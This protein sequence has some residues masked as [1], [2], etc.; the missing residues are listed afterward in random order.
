SDEKGVLK[1]AVEIDEA[2]DKGSFKIISATLADSG[3]TKSLVQSG[4]A[5]VLPGGKLAAAA[6]MTANGAQLFLSTVER[7]KGSIADLSVEL[8]YTYVVQLPAAKGRILFHWDKMQKAADQYMLDYHSTASDDD[9][10]VTKE[11]IQSFMN[12]AAEKSVVEFEFEGYN[13]DS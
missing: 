3:M 11:Q 6:N 5:P 8:N 12:F 7:R 2:E 1:G 13:P 10:T 4:H 9:L